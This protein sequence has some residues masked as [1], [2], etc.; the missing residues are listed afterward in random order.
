MGV[1]R[2]HE[3]FLRSAALTTALLAP[4]TAA[5]GG[6]AV[7]LEWQ[8]PARCPG[9]NA[10]LERVTSLLES[11]AEAKAPVKA[12][13]TVLE[14][15]PGASWELTLET[16]QGEGTWRR[17]IHA[18]SCDEL[19]DAAAL[20]IALVVDPNLNPTPPAASVPPPARA[21]APVPALTSTP[22]PPS[23][24]RPPPAARPPAVSRARVPLHV[25]ASAVGD[26]GSL[27]AAALGGELAA[28]ADLGRARIEA[29]GTVFPEVHKVIARNPERGGDVELLAGG[30]RGCYLI[31][32]T[33]WEGGVC[34]GVEAGRLRATGFGAREFNATEDEL[35]LAGRLGVIADIPVV[36]PLGLRFGLEGL[37]PLRRP[38]FVVPPLGTVHEPSWV[39]LRL[40]LGIQAFFR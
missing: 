4:F 24:P 17:T 29:V 21:P 12:R 9:R 19:A 5:A 23:A 20:I 37:L 11:A 28:G 25:A 38:E 1:P 36:D 27:P 35:W 10:V 30:L 14:P 6:P 3:L 33:G 13:G 22:P 7:S 8:A 34:G 26:V 31:P 16:V 40:E 39:S 2:V 32:W 18:R 15:L